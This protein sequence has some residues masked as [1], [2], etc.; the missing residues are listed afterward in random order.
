MQ[1]L[2]GLI[3]A[4]P[5]IDYGDERDGR[6]D[7]NAPSRLP[8]ELQVDISTQW[9][10]AML[11]RWPERIVTCLAPQTMM[12]S[13]FGPALTFWQGCGLTA[14][15]LCEG[16][17]SR[18]DMAGLA[19]YHA[20]QLDALA[21]LGCPVDSR[22]F[23]ELVAAEKRLP[24]PDPIYTDDD[25][26]DAGVEIAP[27]IAIR[28]RVSTGG[29]R[30]NGFEILRDVITR[31]RRRWAELHLD[32]YLQVRWESEVQAVAREYSRSVAQKGKP[33]TAKQLAKAAETA[34]NHWFGGDISELCKAIGQASP[35][36]PVH[37]LLVPRD[38][39]VFAEQLFSTLGGKPLRTARFVE[40]REV[41]LAQDNERTRHDYFRRL[42]E[43]G[44]RYLQLQE[45]LGAPPELSQFGR[46][47]FAWVAQELW[48][49]VDR[50]WAVYSQAIA[51]VLERERPHVD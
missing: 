29:G 43:D 17:Y 8:T 12:A 10:T 2:W 14:W 27:G 5:L 37:A 35:V 21:A 50:G 1:T 45:A 48:G 39:V 6:F 18:T 13:A 47:K 16:P 11:P 41:A 19:D 33:P 22:L 49:D 32:G 9:R 42:A 25:N 51:A 28:I 34:T 30:R 40:N 7:R 36:D 38:R 23:D 15:F 26:E 3:E 24:E 31:Y 20:K 44:L 4:G 46:S